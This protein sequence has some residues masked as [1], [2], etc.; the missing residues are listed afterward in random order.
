M[1]HF[2]SL[3]LLG[4]VVL[5]AC[6]AL[7]FT[8]LGEKLKTPQRIKG[9]GVDL[10]V[11]VLTVFVLIGCLLSL[12]TF[13]MQMR[14]FES[15]IASAKSE[16]DGLKLA[17]AQAQKTELYP[18]ISLA[19]VDQI[20]DAPKLDWFHCR[21]LP[22][23]QKDWIKADVLPGIETT[24]YRVILRNITTETN[25]ERLECSDD[26]PKTQ[27]TWTKGSFYPLT[28]SYELKKQ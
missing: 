27:R 8:P 21:Y 26:D 12:S 23:G 20:K 17:L 25:I 15:S 9:F 5:L 14:N 22:H 7:V 18:N 16:S 28:P 19:G 3:T 13:Y 6:L 2:S 10:E 11:S 24:T 4:A 1:D